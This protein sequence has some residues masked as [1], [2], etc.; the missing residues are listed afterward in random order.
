MER[1]WRAD[2]D[3]VDNKPFTH[4]D[5][6]DNR[7]WA[8]GDASFGNRTAC[9]SREGAVGANGADKRTGQD[10]REHEMTSPGMQAPACGPR[11][12]GACTQP[13]SRARFPSLNQSR[14]CCH[15]ALPAASASLNRGL[16]RA[17]PCLECVGRTVKSLA[18]E[19]AGPSPKA[20]PGA[21]SAR[22]H[23][24]NLPIAKRFR[25]REKLSADDWDP[26]HERVFFS[27]PLPAI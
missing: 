27:S 19:T 10:D 23:G 1:W 11:L 2:D 8:K 12:A 21:S 5:W 24:S 14:N 13:E 17:S 9:S 18:W 22:G 26:R 4:P 3:V 15:P 16:N 20:W 25:W 7:P 6:T